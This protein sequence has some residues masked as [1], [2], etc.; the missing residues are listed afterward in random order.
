MLRTALGV[1][2]AGWL[3]D[4]ATIEVMLNPD[5]RLW[6]DRLS[7]GVSD[8][9][10][11][12]AAADGERVTPRATN[13]TSTNPGACAMTRYGPHHRTPAKT[14]WRAI[15]TPASVAD[16]T[17]TTPSKR[18]LTTP[19]STAPCLKMVPTAGSKSPFNEVVRTA[20]PH[21]K[22]KNP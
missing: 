14:A 4:P 6:I 17:D 15:P 2:V 9:G 8:T 13:G 3:D 1:S 21:R 12:M 22:P 19:P 7:E 10:E 16:Q 5:G 20:Q 11:R 18:R